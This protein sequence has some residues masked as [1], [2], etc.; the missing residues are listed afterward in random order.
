[1]L[2]KV[3]DTTIKVLKTQIL[4]L[5]PQI[6]LISEDNIYD[7]TCQLENHIANLSEKVEHGHPECENELKDCDRADD[8]LAFEN[9][10]DRFDMDD[11]NH[12]LGF[13]K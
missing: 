5:M 6:I 9:E 4:P 3:S 13:L 12:R 2:K 11:L 7:V 1:M 8:E 10:Q